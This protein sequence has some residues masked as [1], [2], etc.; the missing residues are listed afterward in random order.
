[1]NYR[2]GVKS[3]GHHTE[4]RFGYVYDET[5]SPRRR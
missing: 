5:R 2:L 1:M 4:Y 3:N